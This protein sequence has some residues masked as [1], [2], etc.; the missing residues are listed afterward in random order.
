MIWLFVNVCCLNLLVGYLIVVCVFAC[1]DVDA[2]Y[3]LVGCD[4]LRVNGC[5]FVTCSL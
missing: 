5:G 4:C 3:L 2:C 1:V